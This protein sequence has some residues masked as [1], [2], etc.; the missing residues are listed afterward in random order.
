MKA[1][2][3]KTEFMYNPIGID[4]NKPRLFWNCE[5]GVTQTA[6]E[7]V[8]TNNAGD[9]LWNSGKV[10]SSSMRAAWGGAP[11]APK[12]KVLWQVRL[13]D[14]NGEHGDW[15]EATFETGIDTWRA[16]WITGNYSVDKKQRYPVDCFRKRFETADVVK[17]RLYI[18]ACGIYEAK[19]N[20]QRAGSFVLAPGHTDYRKR[21]QYQTIDVTD[22]LCSGE[23]TLT[24][25][26]ADGWYRG[27]CGAWALKNQYGTE[28]KLI[29]QLEITHKDG[30]VQTILSDETWDW[31]NDGPIRFADNKD[32]EVVDAGDAP[33]YNRKAKLTSRNVVP[34][35]SNNV[36]VTEQ[37]RFKATLLKTPAGKH[38][39]DF[40]QNIAGY[41]AFCVE[42]KAGQKITMRFGEMLDDNGEF[43]QKNIQ[44]ANK[45]I[46]T[47]LQQVIYT[48]KEGR[49]EYKTAFAIFGFRY[50]EVDADF[51]IDPTAFTAI[52][53]YSEMEQ[54]GWFDSSSELLNKLVQNT[55][56][57]AKSNSCDV[58]TDCPTR[59]RH[60]WSGD[61]QIFCS[62]ASYLFDYKTFAEKY[63]RDLYD[64]QKKDGKLP[65]IAPEGGVDSYMKWM[66]GSVGWADAGVIMPY[67]L[68]KQYGD[69]E[70]LH[71]YI[72]G[73]R[74]YAAFMQK[75]CG[76]W[77]PTAKFTGL[78]G[79]D[80]K[81]LSNYGQAYGEWAEPADVHTMTWK[82]CAV[83]HP[84]VATAYTAYIMDLMA[85]IET[86][87]GNADKAKSYEEFAANCRKSYQAL[88]Q[89]KGYSLDTDRQARLV[90][91]LYFDML[92]KAQKEYAEKRL[93]QALEN[94]GWRLG[95]GFLSTPL[96]MDVL[97]K[98]D[99]EAAYKL[100]EN[101]EMPGWL[102]MPKNG[103][104]TI[105]EAWEGNAT[106]KQGIASLNHYS[107]GAVCRWLFDTMCGIKLDRENRFVIAPCPGGSFT[108]ASASYNSVYG[109]VESKWVKK[110]QGIEFTVTV[111]ANCEA[112][113]C[114]PGGSELVQRAGEKCYF[115][116]A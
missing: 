88:M 66:D 108:H 67:V 51:E 98:I 28:T 93:I 69:T 18:T 4:I 81:Y 87:L 43:S 5:D 9:V 99:L 6:Y 60:G 101:E 56:W 38:V 35:A 30:S 32:G 102:F 82:D 106:P 107:K 52:A 62:T 105:W 48:C 19:I 24:V 25:Q 42:A 96:I 16:K 104:T 59:E 116:K 8:A 65:Q 103:A 36:P 47:P 110:E 85:E 14:E 94:Y 21:V 12:T 41:A 70:I 55:T 54:T 64:W 76:K 84:E 50:V 61:A 45:E 113:I 74:K 29:A 53:V 44:C 23:N 83:P 112:L 77:Y 13:W 111:P 75:R 63:I 115:V 34:T 72:D 3:L 73:M 100:L 58:P 7:I 89:T 49:N 78:H 20:G 37:E 97:A 33:T 46:T 79:K 2:R 114:L 40:G 26:L 22:L 11:V 90:R 1:I 68:W 57:S 86:A 95:T 10:E 109:K 27:S 15:S 31:S 92:T 80:R 39:L 91:P 17:A 71:K